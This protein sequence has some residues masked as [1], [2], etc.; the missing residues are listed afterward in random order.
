MKVKHKG[1]E[2][3][4]TPLISEEKIRERLPRLAEEI[5]AA[6]PHDEVLV[7]L[8]VLKGSVIFASDL[9]RYLKMPTEME[10]IRLKSYEGMESTRKIELL[11]PIPPNLENKNVLIVE[12][13]V[14]TGRSLAFLRQE[15]RKIQTRS[16]R[17]CSL[18]NKPEAH[19]DPVHVDFEGFSIGKNFVIGYGLD[20]D[21]KYRNLPYIGEVRVPRF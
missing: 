18:L 15:L 2:L 13:I 9:S 6:Y 5:N 17:L 20:L 10:F 21:G 14:D 19:E 4:V 7:L 16:V 1:K 12:D 3:D 8:I 11:M